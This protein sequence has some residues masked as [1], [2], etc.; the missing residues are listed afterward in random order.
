MDRKAITT[1]R[2]GRVG[3]FTLLEILVATVIG[4]FVAISAVTA[5]KSVL[6]CREKIV[7]STTA[8]AEM[9]FVADTIRQDFF[10]FYRDPE[11]AN[12]KLIGATNLTDYGAADDVMFYTVNRVKARPSQPEGDI[13][14]VEYS[15]LVDPAVGTPYLVRRVWPNP[16]AEVE[17]PAGVVT[18][19]SEKIVSFEVLYY[20]EEQWVEEWPLE[21][22]ELPAL[23]S[24]SLAL[25][26]DV[27]RLETLRHE[28]FVNFPRWPGSAGGGAQI[29]MD[30]TAPA[31]GGSG[32]TTGQPGNPG[33]SGDDQ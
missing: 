5:L 2:R 22:T 9:R 10:N 30:G 26:P 21:M 23:I 7:Q 19:L 12:V 20:Y 11:Y 13:Y 28:F 32:E 14:E 1:F 6:S 27:N 8:S 4:S 15:L 16:V 17:V 29:G 3:G 25:R 33:M 24:V 18:I 31:E